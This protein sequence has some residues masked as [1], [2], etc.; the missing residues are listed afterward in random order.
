MFDKM[1]GRSLLQAGLAVTARRKS[2]S[3]VEITYEENIVTPSHTRKRSAPPVAHLFFAAVLLAFAS[4]TQEVAAGNL[5]VSDVASGDIYELT[6]S[7]VQSTFASGLSAPQFLA[8]NSSGDLF[9]ADSVA[10]NIY[11]YRPSGTQ[12][13]F[14]SG[15]DNPVGLAFNSSGDLFEGDWASGNIYEFTPNGTKSTFASGLTNPYGLAFNSSGDLFVTV[16]GLSPSI[17]E[18]TPNGTQSTFAS[19]LDDP[20]GLAFNSSGDLFEADG[21]SGNIYEY[22]PSGTQST[23]ASGLSNPRVLAFNSNGDLFAAEQ[24]QHLRVHTQQNPIDLRQ[25][26]WVKRTI[27][28]G[29]RLRPRARHHHALGLGTAGVWRSLSAAA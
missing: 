25:R 17:Y 20:D 19:G 14:A 6:P 24:Q 3:S 21:G 16:R 23:F 29:L 7:G 8:F 15:L 4:N 1:I 5:F 12:S 10:G 2:L 9:V 26:I 13:T 18:Y 22:T 27:R 28:A 11:V